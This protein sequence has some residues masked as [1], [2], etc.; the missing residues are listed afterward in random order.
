MQV[1]RVSNKIPKVESK[2]MFLRLTH[3]TSSMMKQ[4]LLDRLTLVVEN[5]VII[6]SLLS[7]GSASTIFVFI[8]PWGIE[9]DVSLLIFLSLASILTISFDIWFRFKPIFPKGIKSLRVRN[10]RYLIFG[11]AMLTSLAQSGSMTVLIIEDLEKTNES[12]LPSYTKQYVLI[13]SIVYDCIVPLLYM[14]FSSKIIKQ[15]EI[16]NKLEECVI[17]KNL[18]WRRK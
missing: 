11:I 12:S 4:I 16:S 15:I 6:L 7:L 18:G 5:I 3:I 9:L 14:I 2:D 17:T 10:I 13:A 8:H 1:K